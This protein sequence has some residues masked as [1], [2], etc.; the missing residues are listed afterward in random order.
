MPNPPSGPR[1]QLGRH[2][3]GYGTDPRLEG[4]A[5]AHVGEGV[6]RDGGVDLVGRRF[7]ERER[8]GIGFHEHV[9]QVQRDGVVEAGG[10]ARRAGQLRVDL[11]DQEAVWVLA[12]TEQLGPGRAD[13]QRQ[14]HRP[15]GGRR[16]LGH[17]DPWREPCQDR[18]HLTEPSGHQLHLVTHGEQESLRRSE[19]ATAVAHP[20]FGEHVVDVEAEGAPEDEV[21]PVVAPTERTEEGIGV[22]RPEPES[23]A[24][25]RPDQ[26][27][28][29]LG[30]EDVGH[31]PNSR[32]CH[33]LPGESMTFGPSER[34]EL[35]ATMALTPSSS[36]TTVLGEWRPSPSAAIFQLGP[37]CSVGACSIGACS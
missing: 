18:C 34:A 13:V 22:R 30:G 4:G 6:G 17:H 31:G 15:A 20:G 26:G 11:D 28:G 24:V 7:V 27:D 21:L 33:D 35:T 14:V 3:V 5:V 23:D 19:E 37:C 36:Q 29:L 25:G 2:H 12:G 16:R 1:G 10:Q 9:D 32:T 8:C